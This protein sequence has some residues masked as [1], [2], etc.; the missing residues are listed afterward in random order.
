[1]LK[2]EG[3]KQIETERLILRKYTQEDVDDFY[4][5]V[6]SDEMVTK[7]VTW[8]KH[9]NKEVTQKIIDKWISEY[10]NDNT[11][12]W[13]VVLK[14]EN[15]VIGSI[16]CVRVDVKNET[17]EIGYVYGSKY[18][19]KGYATE[20]LKVVIDYLM[21][22]QGFFTVSAKHLSLNPASGKVMLKSGMV[23]EGTLRK[24]MIDKTTGK[25][26]DLLTYSICK[27]D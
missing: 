20:A 7:Y 26:D 3:T 16:D 19:N 21:N 27:N 24:R 10:E 17:C 14:S 1:M 13:A 9:E 23:Y 15:V 4:N 12:H 18:W 6:G 5:N 8:D 2:N 11:Y 25:H 22:E